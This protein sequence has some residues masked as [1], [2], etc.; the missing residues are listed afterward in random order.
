M[1]I[2]YLY[3]IL[4]A[5]IFPAVSLINV[6]YGRKIWAQKVSLYRQITLTIVWFPILISLLHKPD[7]LKLHAPYLIASWILGTLYLVSSF[8]AMNLTTVGISRSFVAVARTLTAF[9]IGFFLFQENI[10]MFDL[11][12]WCVIFL[13]F[14][15]LGKSNKEKFTKKDTIWI[16]VSL[17]SGVMISLNL[18]VFKFYADGFSPLESAYLL[19]FMNLVFIIPFIYFSSKKT[20]KEK[21][22]IGSKNFW[23]LMLTAPLILLASFWLAQSVGKIPF[24]IFNTLFVIILVVFIIFSRI[25]FHEKISLMRGV[26]LGTMILWCAIVVML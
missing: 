1:T 6:Y 21:Y 17:F 13:G 14:Y 25:F 19:E 7:L 16:I 3:F 15:I 2:W 20:L 23:I 10:S 24:Y 9:F 8:H 18:L 22:T 26:S 4:P 11:L 5:L 12:G